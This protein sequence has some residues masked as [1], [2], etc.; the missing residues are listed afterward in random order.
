MSRQL[1]RKAVCMFVIE[2]VCMILL[3]I[4]LTVMQTRLSIQNQYENTKEKIE[5]IQGILDSADATAAQ[6]TASYDEVY[7]SKASS[8]AYMAKKDSGFA[9]TDAKMQELAERLDVTNVLIVDRAGNVLAKAGATEADFS[10][11]RYNQ[12][13]TVFETGEVSEAFEVV[14]G[15]TTRRYYGARIDGQREA[16]IEQDPAE[17]H[18]IQEDTSSW[19]STLGN[20]NVGLSGFTFAVSSQDYTFLYYPDEQM[21]GQDSLNA[22][23][24]VEELEDHNDAWLTVNGERFYCG[25]KKIDADNAYVI[26][27]VPEKEIISSRNITVGIVLFIFFAVITVI[28]VYALLIMQEQESRIGE[29]EGDYRAFGK[30]YYNKT[31]GKKIGALTLVGMVLILVVSFFMQTLFSLSLRSMSNK[32]QAE[33]VQKTLERN[34]ED[35][36]LLTAQYNERYLNKCQTASYIL[37]RNP[38]LHTR[39]ELAELSRVLGVEFIILFD[40][41]GRETVTNSSYVNFQISGNPEDQSYEFNKL[42]KGVEYVVQEA[43]PDE[44]SGEYHQYIGSVLLDENGMADGFVQISVVPGKLEEALAA[45][46][47]ASVLDGIKPSGGGFAFAVEKEERTFSWYPD[48]RLIGKSAVEHDMTDNQFRDGY[49]DYIT[50]DDQK[51]YGAGLETDTDYV[52]IVTPDSSLTGTRLPIALASAGASFICLVL[53]TLI[54]SFKHHIEATEEAGNGEEN[55]GQ[56]VKVIMPDGSVRRTEAAASRWSNMTI[57]WADKTPGERIAAILKGLLSLFALVICFAIVF[58]DSF[59]EKDSIFLYVMNGDW[60]R[61]VNVFAITACVMIICA[62]VVI[63]IVLQEVLRLLS[64]SLGARGETVCRLISSFI[65]YVS[66]IAVLY[67][68]FALFGV[69]TGTLLASAGILSLVIG[70]GAKTLV[71]DILAGLFII[72]EGEFQVG[73]IVTVGDWRGTV[74]EIGVRTTKIMDAGQNVKVISNSD[75]NGVINMTRKNSFI[76]CDVG[77]EYGES[78]ERVESILARELPHIKNRLP[79][80]KDGPFYK[81]VV[82]LGDNSVN[83]RIVSQCA[84][85]DRMQLGRDLNRE[86]KLLFDRYDINIPFPQIVLNEPKEYQKATEW[87]KRRAD[88]FSQSQKELAKGMEENEEEK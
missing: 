31:V 43:Q 34:V 20:V 38:E 29:S 80:I 45:T 27:A 22:G 64:K 10:Y 82:S 8:V 46:K 3:G 60:E 44:L 47:L 51:Y 48:K 58:K 72:F 54:L 52:Y 19:K 69:D 71:S 85:S 67:Y 40:R 62:A 61:N 37:S 15:E 33:E 21:I 70:L 25:V 50:I 41:E 23:L 16:V 35:V 7:Q 63:V 30:F 17:L 88:A 24:D 74:Q 73:D 32:R 79:A 36:E 84:E 65:K 56:M 11:A 66:V 53:V 4:F 68:C 87:E 12:L 39:E 76:T 28:I 55:Q 18:Q 49:C 57:K 6:N 26:C 14:T 78:L 9:C 13:R 81:G 42:L 86:M 1:R 59:F 77:I 2:A 5:Q 83:I 75:V